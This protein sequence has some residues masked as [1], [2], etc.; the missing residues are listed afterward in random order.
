MCQHHA[1]SAAPFASPSAR[2]H[3][4]PDLRLLP[5]HLRLDLIFDL[6]GRS[7]SG[8]ATHRIRS[9]GGGAR[10]LVLDAVDLRIE[11]VVAEGDRP[12]RWDHDG[13]RLS[14][15]L[16]SAPR[17][18]EEIV[19]TVRYAVSQPT[20]GLMFSVPDAEAPDRPTFVASDHETERARHWI[21]CIDHPSVR[22]SLDI[23]LRVD[24][25]LTALANGALVAD[26]ALPDG[27]HLWH[28]RLDEPCP[29]YILCVAIGRFRRLDQ[30]TH[31]AFGKSVPVAC[32][33]SESHGEDVLQRTF[34]PTTEML[35]WMTQKL[36][37]AFPFPKYYQFAVPAIGG[38]MENISLVSW[39]DQALLDERLEPDRRLR[40]DVVN[41]HEMA[42]SWFGDHIVVHDFAHVWLKESWASYMESHWV[43]DHLGEDER[44]F[45][46]WEERRDY[47]G[48]AADRYVRPIVTRQFDS[49]WDMYDQH[50]YPGGATRLHMLQQLLGPECFWSAVRRYVAEFGGRT[51][52]T[53]DFRRVLEAE[54]GRSLTAFFDHW[55]HRPGFP[56]VNLE[57]SWREEEGR[58]DVVATQKQVDES[59]GIGL[60]PLDIPFAVEVA[61]GQWERRSLVLSGATATLRWTLE[62]RPLAVVPDPDG[63]LVVLWEGG[64]PDDMLRRALG[65]ASVTGRLWAA[66]TLGEKGRVPHL[67]ALRD[68]MGIEPFR[69]VRI[70]IVRALARSAHNDAVAALAAALGSERDPSV[71]LALATAC[72]GRRDPR[73]RAAILVLLDGPPLTWLV[74]GA[75]WKALGAQRVAEDQER[76]A[77]AL[78]GDAGWWGH[79]RRGLVSALGEMR[80]AWARERLQAIV[81]DRNEKRQV[82]LLALDALG[83]HGRGLVE[84]ERIPLAEA[85]MSVLADSDYGTR[86]AAARALHSM[87]HRDAARAIESMLPTLAEQD[88]PRLRKAVAGLRASGAA[89]SVEKWE[90]RIEELEGRVRELE[91]GRGREA[92]SPR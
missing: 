66:R 68:A 85:V 90:R 11:G 70:E 23:L 91:E 5:V 39:D 41:V 15:T 24:E 72:A 69:G 25:G 54:S 17:S 67:R 43:A 78:R 76:F 36:G 10:T 22:T 89:P 14:I 71:L 40:M 1:L 77:A 52:E 32:F 8:T 59:K 27:K 61:E 29:S 37:T 28:W 82:R 31:T 65:H 62:R 57:V 80:S 64:A 2:A 16:E 42:H 56:K 58:L 34:G 74:D 44:A 7:V 79:R 9:R 63:D 75:L 21:P 38:A 19:L 13:E 46:L 18:G 3:H 53:D 51:V 30:R 92:P 6:P 87:G 12:L 81:L 50:L 88:R 86:Q 47:F 60:F 45:Y 48:E 55:F 33:A 35:D 83:T 49:S 4:A 73:L 84:G 20:T 26:E